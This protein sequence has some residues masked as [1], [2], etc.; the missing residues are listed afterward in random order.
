MIQYLEDGTLPTEDK[1]AR[2]IV[3]CK[4]QYVL[5]DKVLCHVERDKSLRLIPPQ[6]NRK[7]LFHYVDSVGSMEVI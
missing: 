4:S 7:K 5:I 2:E 1:I 6:I 3:L